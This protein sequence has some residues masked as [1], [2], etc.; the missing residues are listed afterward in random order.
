MGSQNESLGG[1]FVP[2]QNLLLS[3][4]RILK[5]SGFTKETQWKNV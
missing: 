1:T 5:R 2:A 4:K 3:F